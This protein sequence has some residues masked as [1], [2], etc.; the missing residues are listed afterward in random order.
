MFVKQW[1]DKIVIAA[2]VTLLFVYASYRPKFHMRGDMPP[3]FFAG[4]ISGPAQKRAAEEK[5]A[6]AYW[7]CGVIQMQWKYGYAS[8]LPEDPPP[9]FT[10]STQEFGAAAADPALRARYWGK[11]REVWYRPDTW[12]REYEWDFHWM[13]SWIRPSA[14]W[15]QE[16]L[17]KFVEIP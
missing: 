7:E 15:L 16:K 10:V 13:T 11:L 2:V 5:I 8:R 14:A 3:E 4:T 17:G 6:R 1:Y 12:R 9:E